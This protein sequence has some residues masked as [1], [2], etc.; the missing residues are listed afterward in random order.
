MCRFQQ[1][2]DDIFIS[3][4]KEANFIFDKYYY[5]TFNYKF[6]PKI[7]THCY[8]SFS[9]FVK[10]SFKIPAKFIEVALVSFGIILAIL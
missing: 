9:Q 8:H 1:Y 5:R 3:W 7:E 4:P 6:T 10:N 2:T